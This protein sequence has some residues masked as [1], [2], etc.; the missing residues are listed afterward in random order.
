MR[1]LPGLIIFDLFL[2]TISII[3]EIPEDVLWKIYLFDL[4]VCIIL[5]GE[6]FINLILSSPKKDYI[7]DKENML[8]LIASIPFDFILPLIS[9]YAIPVTFLRYLRLFK[10]IRVFNLAK[11]DVI[12]DLFRKTALGK[13]LII[14]V[15]TI[16]IFWALF[17]FFSPS[18]NG[19]DD[20]YFVIVTLTTVG[21]GDVTPTT[22]NEK[23]LVI[24][25]I[26]VGIF[27]FS[28]IT[29]AISSFLT[30]QDIVSNIKEAIDE[31][32]ENIMSELEH[33]RSENKQLKIETNELK[34]EINELKDI[35]KNMK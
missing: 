28:T 20:F 24:I 22:Y 26:L 3:F 33:V 12:K 23:V 35:I 19:F 11:F 7:L 34:D 29:A 2:I 13:V 8:G 30:D 25:L 10:L 31:K 18:Y 14:T 32:S 15:V 17:Y 1:F 9:P 4:I 27:I 21:Y 16:L 5:L 6:Y